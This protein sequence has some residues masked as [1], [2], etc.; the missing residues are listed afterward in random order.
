VSSSCDI[1]RREVITQS[2]GPFFEKVPVKLCDKFNL[3]FKV[4]FIQKI[5]SMI[6]L[7]TKLNDRILL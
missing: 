4:R 1:D 2:V 5:N 3:I 6:K 7:F